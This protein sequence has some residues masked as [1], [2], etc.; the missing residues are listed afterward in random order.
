[1]DL[2]SDN[3]GKAR[4]GLDWR[5]ITSLEDILPNDDRGSSQVGLTIER[6]CNDA[7]Q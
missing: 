6:I 3:P 1:M 2:L 5:A 4:T 7:R